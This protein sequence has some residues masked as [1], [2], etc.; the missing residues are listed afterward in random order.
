MADKYNNKEFEKSSPKIN[1]IIPFITL[2]DYVI[3]SVDNTL[4]LDYNNFSLILLPDVKLE[5]PK[6][7]MQ[8]KR[9]KFLVTGKETISKKRNIGIKTFSDCDYYAF[10]DSDAFPRK[11]WLKNAINS[12]SEK[13]WAVGGPNITPPSEPLLKRVVGNASKSIL[14]T[15]TYFFRKRIAKSRFCNNLPTCNLI[16]SQQA[17]EELN[18]FNEKLV[19]GEDIDLCTR[20]IQKGYKILYARE[21]VVFHHNRSLF[22]PF[23][24]QRITWGLSV[25]KVMRE[26]PSLSNLFLFLP[27]AFILF[28]TVL[29]ISSFYWSISFLL[30]TLIGLFYLSVMFIEALR[31]SEKFIEIPGTFTALII[32]NIFP[33]VGSLWAL[34]R[35]NKSEESN[36]ELIRK[37]YRNF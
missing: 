24:K 19:T 4:K 23:L 10:I 9:V 7:W 14:I 26:N 11:D 8:D 33:G 16:V 13:I 18:G 32:G 1:I 31:W 35:I 17:I 29:G 36:R 37:I 30:F 15:G 3:E 25:F 28:M 22:K 6:R 5:L 21:V 20:I 34:L 2:N 27:L 12:F